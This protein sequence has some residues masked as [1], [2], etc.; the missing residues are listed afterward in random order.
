MTLSRIISGAVLAA[1]AASALG[2]DA[3][4]RPYRPSR[5]VTAPGGADPAGDVTKANAAARVQPAA[6][7]FV[8]ANQVFA[9]ADGALFEVYT[10][11]GKV[12]DIALQPGESLTGN[13]PVAAGDTVRWIIGDT[14]S[15][16]GATRQVHILIKPTQDRL[17]TNLVVNTDR[18]TYHIELQAQG[19]T[20][21]AAVSWRYPQDELLAVQQRA[22]TA[23]A[24]APIA[25]GMD[26]TKLNFGYRI[27]GD[28]VNWRPTLAFDDGQHVFIELPAGIA[29][30]D[31]PPLF[32]IGAGGA[33]ELVN[34]RVSNNY[35]IVDRLFDSAELRLGDKHSQKIVRIR[36]L[37]PAK[38]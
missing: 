25:D 23:K 17:S 12:T 27:D 6:D 31:L 2:A 11:V 34:Y 36:R 3:H 9:Y 1:L 20:Y 35:F 19:A 4:P 28:H 7:G 30:T 37:E 21:M 15:G 38:S 5:N 18:R 8:N 26:P 32:V 16:A 24:A 10:A 29:T 13:G 33:A 22:E 14:E